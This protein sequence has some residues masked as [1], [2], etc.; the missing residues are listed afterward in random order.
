MR[1]KV[2]LAPAANATMTPARPMPRL[3]LEGASGLLMDIGRVLPVSTEGVRPVIL[4]D[5]AREGRL[6]EAKVTAILTTTLVRLAIEGFSLDVATPKPL[7]IG[8][9]LTVKAERDGA[10]IRLVTQGPI[11]APENAAP[12]VE[13][14]ASALSPA[15]VD[16][17]TTLLALVRALAVDAAILADDDA[18]GAPAAGTG[19]TA[20]E[21]PGAV[22]AARDPLAEGRPGLPA[23]PGVPQAP[24]TT[25][26]TSAIIGAGVATDRRSSP[27]PEA[28]SQAALIPPPA[29]PT[30]SR[31]DAGMD[32]LL[33]LFDATVRDP[34]SLAP[35][36]ARRAFAETVGDAE[37]LPPPPR[38]PDAFEPETRT[39]PQ[40][41][42][43]PE[44]KPDIEG[45]AG[46]TRGT[47]LREVQ[48]AMAFE[49]YAATA[50]S[51]SAPAQQ[52]RPERL[53]Q[54]IIQMPLHIPG[55]PAPLRLHV[56]RQD[57][58]ET[59]GASD[60]PR[61]PSW[62][63][64]F[65]AE[66]GGLGLV[67]AAITYAERQVGVRLWSERGE[68]VSLFNRHADLLRDALAAADL[69][70]EALTI[71]EGRPEARETD[72]GAATGVRERRL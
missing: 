57:E 46:E 54:F 24:V 36:L 71:A 53:A 64:R 65:A 18:S 49:L 25:A 33:R 52:H 13:G 20:R 1:G 22:I 48:R 67:H 5:A 26:D 59:T 62:T 9:S 51:D 21:V 11:R 30:A 3:F 15:A 29:S 7:P 58:P 14:R 68:T 43:V 61:A 23:Q 16:P 56:E 2:S 12:L 69:R 70:V 55:D 44:D 45:G 19:T 4:L 6:L 66:A 38:G 27:L 37:A 35:M 47:A 41:G 28:G 60:G 72:A 40:R 42:A 34:A 50:A 17:P 10:R 8:A 63:I 31:P 32:L 39:P